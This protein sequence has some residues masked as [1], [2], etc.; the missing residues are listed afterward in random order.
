MKDKNIT[1]A[2]LKLIG[3]LLIFGSIGIFAKYTNLPSDVIA[4]VRGFIGAAFLAIIKLI[5]DKKFSFKL[6]GHDLLM[7]L[8][9]G[10]FL[11]INWILLFES[12]KHTSVAIA[13]LCYYLAPAFV[14][15]ASPLVLKERLSAKKVFCLLIS[16][17]GMA[18]VSNLFSGSL[19]SFSE[20]RGVI[21][22]TGAAVMYAGLTITN[23]KITHIPSFERTFFQL[24]FASAILIP[25][26]VFCGSFKGISFTLQDI[27]LIAVIGI[28]HTGLA[29]FLYFSSLE[30]LNV[31]TVALW[32]Y[33]DPIS[34]IIFSSIIFP[35]EKLGSSGIIGAIFI[36]GSAILCEIKFKKPT[37]E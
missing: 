8:L 10:G 33:I 12:Y 32:G 27:L 24:L 29:F 21:F 37:K 23:K 7:L 1:A 34:A 5:F 4:I 18:F 31:Q 36:L 20:I 2:K 14:L 3:S 35:A 22:G 16:L 30:F 28:I 25:Y 11:G 19:P 9:S 6:K 15:I 26:S 13:T 17:V